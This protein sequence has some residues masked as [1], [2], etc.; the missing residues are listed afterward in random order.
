M[1]LVKVDNVGNTI[2]SVEQNGT[3]VCR[4]CVE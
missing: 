1:E 4:S 2:E 3:D